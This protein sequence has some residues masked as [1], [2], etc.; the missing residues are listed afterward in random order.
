MLKV[1][2]EGCRA[3]YRVDE[4]RIP[5]G[6]LKMRCPKCG[7]T[8][9]VNIGE[10]ALPPLAPPPSFRSALSKRTV[11]GI[12][13]PDVAAVTLLPPSEPPP[14]DA[15]SE[16]AAGVPDDLPLPVASAPA[17]PAVPPSLPRLPLP[18]APTGELDLPVVGERREG[19]PT[20][21]SGPDLPVFA[22]KAP[23][24]PLRPPAPPPP[25][26]PPPPPPI[27]IAPPPASPLV[28]DDLPAVSPNVAKSPTGIK[29]QAGGFSDFGDLPMPVAPAPLGN[30]PIPVA[31]APLGNL[32]VPTAPA[33]LIDLPSPR[34]FGANTGLPSPAS[35]PLPMPS[36]TSLPSIS[37]TARQITGA[38]LFNIPDV[39]SIIVPKATP[40]PDFGDGFGELDLPS[41]G[42]LSGA[43][44]T[45]SQA[46]LPSAST[47]EGM[48]PSIST[49]QAGAAIHLPKLPIPSGIGQQSP[50]P[51]PAGPGVWPEPPASSAGSGMGGLFGELGGSPTAGYGGSQAGPLPTPGEIKL[52]PPQTITRKAGGG[53]AFGEVD[54]SAGD[55]H[56][57]TTDGSV[58]A[59]APA[60]QSWGVS[61]LKPKAADE[62]MEFG[63]IPQEEERGGAPAP[64]LGSPTAESTS[65]AS[66]RRSP[67]SAPRVESSGSKSKAAK[68]MLVGLAVF[69]LGGIAMSA[70]PTLGA[71]GVHFIGDTISAKKN[72]K[73]FQA[74]IASSRQQLS[75]DTSDQS[76]AAIAVADRLV[77]DA[78]R[79]SSVASYA[80]W[81]GFA[82]EVRFGS[83]PAVHAHATALVSRSAAEKE[84]RYM[85]LARAAEAAANGEVAKA[86]QSVQGLALQ[87]PQ[88]V[89]IAVLEG[90]VDLLAGEH[91]HALGVWERAAKLEPSARTSFGKARAL[92]GLGETAKAREEA[93]ATL[94]ASKDHVGARILLARLL[95]GEKQEEQAAKMLEEIVGVGA[96]PAGRLRG[97]ASTTEQVT[98]YTQLGQ[99]NL[100]RSR[101]SAS[102]AAFAEALKIDPKD[103]DALCG[104]GEVLYREGRYAEGLARFEAGMQANPESLNAKIGAAKTKIAL[105]RLQEA[106][107]ILRKLRERRPADPVVAYW[108]SQVEDALGNKAEVEKILVEAIARTPTGGD[109]INLY[110]ALSQFLA[111]QGRT[112]EADAKLAEARTKLPD[113]PAIHKAL[114]NVALTAG[115]LNDAKAEFEV[116]LASDA[117]DLQSL[118]NLGVTL[119]R[120]GKFDDAAEKFDKVSASDKNFPGLALERGVL[121]ET[122]GQ[123]QRALEMYQEALSKAPNDPDLMLR[124]GSAE[125]AAGQA[126][127]GEEI[128]RKVLQARPNSAEANHYL[129]RAQLLKGTNLSEALRYLKRATEIDSHRAEYWLYIGWAAN[130]AGQP[131]TAE[132]ALHHALELDQSLA[133]AYWQRGVLLRR[134]GAVRD[135]ERD[136]NKALE[137]KPSRHEAYA[138]LAECYED[139]SKW[140]QATTAWRKAIASDGN[141]SFWRYKLGRLYYNNGNRGGAAEELSKA[142]Q[143]AEKEARPPWLWE[144]YL[145]LAESDRASGRRQEAIDHYREFLKLAPPDS[146]FRVDAIKALQG[147]GA[148]W[149]GK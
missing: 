63:A 105:E 106:K 5:P 126:S 92:A 3:P 83:E 32:P 142:I 56:S 36:G 89:D 104:F 82:R 125:V 6:G 87:S 57:P 113:S 97:I 25:R 115:R 18:A 23:M 69:A 132:S 4:R 59:P 118:F 135:A 1:E 112:Q 128:L 43:L 29:T 54:L 68:F 22:P 49:G 101:M 122:S 143:L 130:E 75:T 117:R 2:C 61:A 133:D 91:K 17:M 94:K 38:V 138:T 52:P 145:M 19:V 40:T 27:P 144:A 21:G 127:Q 107:E 77:Q 109:A 103:A 71:F 134:Q 146:P 100:E 136:L 120:M 9:V 47:G 33:P 65:V 44:P 121:F 51:V 129:G 73:T 149:E 12:G 16:E 90:E 139:Q 95:L 24:P 81:L 108:L 124:V 11:L 55:S 53:V 140:D 141:R 7:A 76:E 96:A 67:A 66:D 20:S 10:A 58:S 123:V 72:E 74:M 48:L 60:A 41:A 78:P 37:K 50:A 70:S 62:D 86:R 39:P 15:F 80:A 98:A 119:R 8:F 137:L 84:S 34:A 102:E 64:T 131:P 31:P 148:P 79:F 28:F 116:A 114:G 88:D 45:I 42:D 46:G 26:P 35:I 111:S 110:V 93:A 99:I 85:P 147:L 13:E 14:L 30:L